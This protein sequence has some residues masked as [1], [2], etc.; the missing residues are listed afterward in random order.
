[1]SAGS[2]FK[3][4]GC[5]APVLNVDGSPALDAAGKPRKKRIGSTCPKL[6]RGAGWNPTHGLW[7][8]QLEFRL[9]TAGRQ[10]VAH[11]GLATRQE[12]EE[13]LAVVRN[14]LAIAD[15]LPDDADAVE[16]VKLDIVARIRRDLAD[17]HRLPDYDAVRR[18]IAA[19]QPL[20][21]RMT[22]GQWLTQ[23][24]T[25]RTDLA[26]S[27]RR[28]Y[29]GYVEQYLIPH[30]GSIPLDALRVH[31]L[32]RMFTAIAEQSAKAESV[33]AARRAAEQAAKAAWHGRDWDAA[34]EARQQLATVPPYRP[35]CGEATRA[36]IR[37]TLR[38]A[39]SAACAQQL[40][41][42]NMAA[43]VE[44]PAGRPPRA[45]V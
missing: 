6:R 19:G 31:H 13:Q 23:W 10:V 18:A 29:T 43:L 33:N 40:I 25:G 21:D 44:I 7:H 22:V 38:S 8:F 37:A 39:L 2:V 45:R 28:V 16:K 1:M 15:R 20:A 41:V 32:T 35:A 4:C 12:A 17:T 14:L 42:V 26:L 3:K 5:R 24:L 34:R 30:L 9:P 36:R 27:S 11:S